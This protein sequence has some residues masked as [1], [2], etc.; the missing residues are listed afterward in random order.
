MFGRTRAFTFPE[1]LTMPANQIRTYFRRA[2]SEFE[3]WSRA[4]RDE[5]T[6]RQECTTASYDQAER[7]AQ[8]LNVVALIEAGEPSPLDDRL[9]E[10]CAEL[11][12]KFGA[13]RLSENAH[14]RQFIAMMVAGNA[15]PSQ[16]D[17][18]RRLRDVLEEVL[19]SD[20]DMPSHAGTLDE[21]D[22]AVSDASDWLDAHQTAQQPAEEAG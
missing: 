16:A 21:A 17:W 8:A 7:I 12:G 22:Q 2:T 4:G 9:I 20:A 14:V 19:S 1:I 18:I 11:L 13:R 3:V 15:N 5:R 10:R 6:L